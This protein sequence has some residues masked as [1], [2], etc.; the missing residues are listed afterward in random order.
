MKSSDIAPSVIAPSGRPKMLTAMGRGLLRRCPNCGRG[1]LYKGS[2]LK[3]FIRIIDHCAVCHE[4]LGHIR[5]DDIPAYFTVF[6]AGHFM[7]SG[8][9][10]VANRQYPEWAQL[11]VAIPLAVLL[12]YVLLPSIK[13]AVAARLWALGMATGVLES[14]KALAPD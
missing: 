9:L 12:I 3:R 10:S 5:A 2:G 1:H 14:E 7:L 8:L 4:Q 11:T 6:I 13:G